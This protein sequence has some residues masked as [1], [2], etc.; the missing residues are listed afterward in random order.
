MKKLVAKPGMRYHPINRGKISR[1]WLQIPPRF[2]WSSIIA[3]K[4]DRIL[5]VDVEATCWEG[6]PRPGQIS[7]IIESGLCVPDVT[8]LAR[9]EQRDILVRPV[10]STISPYQNSRSPLYVHDQPL[11][12][13]GSR[14]VRATITILTNH[15]IVHMFSVYRQRFDNPKHSWYYRHVSWRVDAA[16]SSPQH[17]TQPYTEH[18]G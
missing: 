12:Q 5:V 16:R 10:C 18:T 15:Q 11:A 9:V 2:L 3:R 14:S 4:L 13:G 1:V 8:T 17:R 6:D 7:E